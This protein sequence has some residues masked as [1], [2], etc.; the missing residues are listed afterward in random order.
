MCVSFPAGVA[1][2]C[3]CLTR[4]GG[5]ADEK[6]ERSKKLIKSKFNEYLATQNPIMRGL[7]L[8]LKGLAMICFFL[9]VIFFGIAAYHTILWATGGSAA[10]STHGLTV[11]PACLSTWP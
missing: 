11:E 3:G 8:V 7:H 6:N 1:D 9:P 2:G 5:S 10:S 4:E